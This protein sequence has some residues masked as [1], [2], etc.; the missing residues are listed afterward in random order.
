LPI[1]SK[2]GSVCARSL[3][4]L[5]ASPCRIPREHGADHVDRHHPRAATR[6]APWFRRLTW[7]E[8]DPQRHLFVWDETEETLVTAAIKELMPPVL[9]GYEG[10]WRAERRFVRHLTEFYVERYGPWAQDWNWTVG[11]GDVD[12]GVVGSWC[13]GA[14]S[15][16]TPDETA[17]RAVAALLEW[18]GWLEE[19]A[20]RFAELAP[21]PQAGPEERSWHLERAAVRLVTR[22]VDLTGGESGW[23]GTCNLTLEWFLTSNGMDLQAARAAVAD[24]IGGRFES[25]VRPGTTVI[26]A[27]GED[28]AVGLTGHPPYRDHREHSDLEERHDRR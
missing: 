21:P 1:K 25:W 28:L 17:A 19:L 3:A 5:P 10:S 4:E 6:A 14:H 11:E 15:V 20:E 27:V 16:T 8:V 9:D 24:A 23:Y 2:F 18:R 12:G 26:D 13:C 7:P 22:I